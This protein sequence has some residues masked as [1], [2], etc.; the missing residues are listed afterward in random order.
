MWWINSLVSMI[1][2]ASGLS[3]T[4]LIWYRYGA[5]QES[6]VLLLA[7]SSISILAQL[8][9]VGVEQIMYFYAEERNKDL[10]EST[11]FYSLA[12]TWALLS[13]GIFALLFVGL[14][15]FYVLVVASG[16]SESAKA[17][18]V[19]LMLCLTPQ[20]IL[21]PALH[22]IRA[23]W[24]L[25]RKFGRAYLL[26]AMNSLILLTSLLLTFVAGEA[27]I[28]SLGTLALSVSLISLFGFLALNRNTMIRP[29]PQDWPRI[30]AMVF[31][32]SA[33]KGANSIHN[34]LVQA[35]LNSVLSHMPVGSLSVFQYAKRLADGVFAITAG[36]QVMMY[37]SRC[38]TAVSNWN[39]SEMRTNV[40]E[41]LKTFLSMFFV[42]ALGVYL[43]T[44]LALAILGKGFDQTTID[45]IRLVYLAVILWYMII[46]IETLSVGIILAARNA[47]ALFRVN[48]TFILLFFIWSRFYRVDKAI[49]LVLTTAGF[50][51]LSFILFTLSAVLI[52]RGRPAALPKSVST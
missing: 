37:H 9:L 33:I 5:S 44:P 46:G 49:D 20:L 42:M 19:F 10:A 35:L 31:H 32:S 30:K 6:D 1:N 11:R 38:A 13:G 41:F 24:A 7:T 36:P 17:Q 21:S 22:V 50:Q 48:L 43:M 29:R 12:F 14:A 26:S 51:A 28:S 45:E 8:S 27:D 18:A 15:K 34:F 23:R 4:A 16:F 39:L 47:F 25:D 40:R 2:V 52:I 3:V